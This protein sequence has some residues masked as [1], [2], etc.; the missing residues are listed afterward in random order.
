MA[1]QSDGEARGPDLPG[2]ALTLRS[3]AGEVFAATPAQF[4]ATRTALARQAKSQGSPEL[5]AQITALRKP[6]V[7]AWALNHLVRRRPELLEQLIDLGERLRSAQT[8]L[9]A[10]ALR[11]LRG[12]RDAVLRGLVEGASTEAAAAGQRLA[13]SVVDQVRDTL[14]AALADAEASRAVESGALTRSLTYSGFG[15]VDLADAVARTATGVPLAV[16][17]GGRSSSVPQLGSDSSLASRSG[18]Q[19]DPDAERERAERLDRERHEGALR[20]AQLAL[21]RAEREVDA[22]A[23]RVRQTREASDAARERVRRARA[24]LAAA[25]AEDE[26]RLLEVSEA[27]QQRS[28]AQQTRDAAEA[29][30]QELMQR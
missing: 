11:R 14:V 16:I 12:E 13:A 6:S 9:D 24:D 22:A 8:R 17:R 25:E 19:A 3:A 1:G 23:G 10:S 21:A 20:E 29:R 7:A 2:E 5:A 18:R 15:E 30:L 28:R 4:V 27:V 26:A